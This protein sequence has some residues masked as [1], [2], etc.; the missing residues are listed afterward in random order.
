MTALP[1]PNIT[2]NDGKQIPQLGLGVFL[3][4]PGETE[5]IVIDALEVGY[6]HIDTARIYDNEAEVGAAIAK[7]GIPRDEL[8][9]T[10]KLWNSDQEDPLGAFNASMDRLGLERVDLYLVHWPVPEFGTAL[11]AWKGLIEIAESGRATSIGVS[12]F[13]IPHLQELLDNTGIVPAVNQIELHPLNQRRE[14][15]AFCREHGI[16]IEAWGP[17]AQGKSDLFERPEITAAAAAH[18]KTPAQV[19]LRWH[20]QHDTII[21]PKTTRRER[22]VENAD[23]LDFELTA[24]EM[25]AIDGLDAQHNFGPDPSTF[26]RR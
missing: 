12:N 2:L 7:S 16:A 1:I 20:L 13:E 22:M 4:E 25:A 18:G 14:L 24:A 15:R 23:I 26:N 3:V 9:I 5:R 19:I 17:L 11:G 6:R 10:T 21:F 8:F